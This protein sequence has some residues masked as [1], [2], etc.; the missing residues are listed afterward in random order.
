MVVLSGSFLITI[1][2]AQHLGATPFII[3][4]IGAISAV[5]GIIGSLVAPWFQKRLS[6][7]QAI[8]MI[9]IVQTI[10]WPL[11]IFAPNPYML[12]VIAAALFIVVPI[13]NGIIL[14]YR[15]VLIP[16]HLPGRVNSSIRLLSFG[17]QP[18][19]LALTGVL[20]QQFGTTVAVLS[21]WVIFLGGTLLSILNPDIRH[22]PPLAQAGPTASE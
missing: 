7:G 8:L 14:S 18:L 6:F 10:I 9:M 2:L 5:G 19:G 15:L 17:F 22:A 20:L 16:D 3:G 11:Q 21:L 4:I 13:F 1:L 12:G